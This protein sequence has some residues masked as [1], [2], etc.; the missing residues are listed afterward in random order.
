MKFGEQIKAIRKESGLTQ[1]QF[2]AKLD[3]TR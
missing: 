3:V 2:A 1:E